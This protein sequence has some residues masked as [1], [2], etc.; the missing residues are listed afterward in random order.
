MARYLRR[1]SSTRCGGTLTCHRCNSTRLKFDFTYDRTVDVYKC[2]DCN[3]ITRYQ[4]TPF[5]PIRAGMSKE[6]AQV[7]GL[8]GMDQKELSRFGQVAR[9][10]QQGYVYIPGVGKYRIKR[11]N[12]TKKPKVM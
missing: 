9:A 1:R 2:L 12:E 4:V 3:A 6:E 5:D 8:R 11:K 10:N 7:E